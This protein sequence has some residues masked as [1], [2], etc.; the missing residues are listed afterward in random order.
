MGKAQRLLRRLEERA[1]K[2]GDWYNNHAALD[3]MIKYIQSE[4]ESVAAG[5]G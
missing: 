2:R 3:L 5:R 1:L 4:T